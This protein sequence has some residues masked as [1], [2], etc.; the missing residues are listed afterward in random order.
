MHSGLIMAMSITIK[1]MEVCI[2]VVTQIICSQ[3]TMLAILDTPAMSQTSFGHYGQIIA[4]VKHP[5]LAGMSEVFH[6]EPGLVTNDLVYTLL[7]KRIS[8]I[9][10]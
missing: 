4:F 3:I 10:E 9:Y 8:M 2:D 5:Y 7:H 6:I 1:Q